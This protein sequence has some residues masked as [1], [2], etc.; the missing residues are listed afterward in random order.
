MKWGSIN[1]VFSPPIS[2]KEYTADFIANRIDPPRNLPDNTPVADPFHNEADK[3]SLLTELSYKI[4]GVLDR[5]IVITSTAIVSTVLL[6]YPCDDLLHLRH[7][8]LESIALHQ[9]DSHPVCQYFILFI[10]F[11]SFLW[12]FDS[13]NMPK[14]C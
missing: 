11:H 14:G 2:A 10:P 12:I 7:P 8:F 3:K 6:A 13:P 4:V 9:Y 1:I 5:N